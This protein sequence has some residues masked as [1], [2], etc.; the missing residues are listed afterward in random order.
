MTSLKAL[1]YLV[2]Q[3]ERIIETYHDLHGLAEPSWEEAKTSFYLKDCLQHAGF[4]VRTFESH[5]GLI[6]E[7]KGETSHVIALRADMD[8]LVQEVNGVVKA[9]HSC[10]HDAHSTMVLHSA[11][12]VASCKIKPRNTLR[13]IFQPAEEKGEGA[14]QMIQDGALDHVTMLFGVHLRPVMEV[15]YG[16]A[17]PVIIHAASTAI[18][19]VIMGIQAHASRPQYGKNVIE[20]ASMLI[21]ALQTIRLQAS[22]PFSIK[23]TQLQAGGET[24][25]VIPDKATFTLDMRAQTNEGMDELKEQTAHVIKTIASLEDT[26]IEWEYYGDVPSATWSES[27]I[28]HAKNAISTVLGP[29]NLAEACIT[30]GAEDFHFYTKENPDLS[31]TMIG[32]GC[33]LL[34]G[35]HHPEMGFNLNALLYGTQIL[36]TALLE[37]DKSY[38]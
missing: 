9:N 35:L 30:Q 31:A 34:P 38:E 6:A 1:H 36:T 19:G 14:L 10:G 15:P 25:N 3:K 8:A 13:F 32:L 27:M 21:Q 20:T 2:E 22:C 12:A 7:I 5:F 37:A 26:M 28:N 16:K 4:L 17:S 33:N 23:I 24:S 29:E 11:L 18:R